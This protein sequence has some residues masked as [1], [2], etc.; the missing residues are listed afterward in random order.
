MSKANEMTNP[1]DAVVSCCTRC[2]S[3]NIDT[4]RWE[5]GWPNYGRIEIG[6]AAQAFGA[7]CGAEH[8]AEPEHFTAWHK[9]HPAMIENGAQSVIFE[10]GAGYKFDSRERYRLCR[11][12]QK[13][14]L[15]VIGKFFKYGS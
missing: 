13:S 10:W 12:C 3:N 6:Y 14:L 4:G 15:A 9:G 7:L 11:G 1:V 2:G 5:D 8:C